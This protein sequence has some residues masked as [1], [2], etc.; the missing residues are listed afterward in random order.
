M[1]RHFLSAEA[2]ARFSQ[3]RIDAITA[4]GRL[5]TANEARF[6]IV[7][8]D[9]FESNQLSHETLARSMD[10]LRRLPVPVFLLPG[11]HDPLDGASIF[12]TPEFIDAPGHIVVIRD[13]EPITVPGLDNVEVVGAPWKS[14]RPTSD[15]VADLAAALE[16]ARG[17]TRVAVGHGQVDT[18]S[19]DKDK[20]EI[21][22]LATAE[23]AIAGHKFH[24]LGLGDR[25]S[26]TAVGDSGRIHYS[27][28]PVATD[29]DEIDPNKAL[30]VELD[31]ADACQMTALDVGDWHFIREKR[32]MNGSEDLAAF[33]SWLDSLPAPERSVLKIGF[34][35]TVS[36][37]VAAELD[38]L[39]EKDAVRFA[40][41]RAWE[42][43]TDLARAPD[44]LDEDSVSL[45]GYAK[46]SWQELFEASKAGDPVAE[47]ALMLLYR[48]AQAGNR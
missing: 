4:L 29:F 20:P 12:A 38:D 34:E 47:D 13:F 32:S 42:R 1:T 35:G 36:L 27:G 25:H 8:G 31:G 19:P 10:A 41:L 26:I 17:V 7:A 28:A 21:I 40:S 15:L 45:S 2:A 46:D 16:P 37:K 48:L 44:E 5:A 39:M 18:L 11:N 9:A 30:L 24:Y 22:D 23:R 6:I 14:K 43:V 3:A 33:R